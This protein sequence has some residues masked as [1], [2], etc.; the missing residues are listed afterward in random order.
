MKVG[1]YLQLAWPLYTNWRVAPEA[2]RYSSYREL[3]IMWMIPRS[4]IAAGWVSFNISHKSS[5]SDTLNERRTDKV[6]VR[7]PRHLSCYIHSV[8]HTFL[9]E[10]VH[11]DR[12][13]LSAQ[14]KECNRLRACRLVPQKISATCIKVHRDPIFP[15]K[16]SPEVRGP[17]Q[18]GPSEIKAF[19][20]Q[21]IEHKDGRT[22]ARR[23]DM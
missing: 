15:V 22:P 5:A 17:G 18:L 20:D 13:P 21:L 14:R 8:Y 2:L 7:W 6:P 9:A 3:S 12:V 19:H 16:S 1:I 10:T 23:L 11:D 4:W